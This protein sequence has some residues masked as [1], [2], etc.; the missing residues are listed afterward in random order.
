MSCQNFEAIIIGMARAQ[1]LEASARREALAHIAQCA[2]CADKL[3]EQQALTAAVRVTARNLAVEGASAGV[4]HALRA[5][6]RAQPA[7][8]AASAPSV[9]PAQR[10]QLAR[11]MVFAAAAILLV[12]FFAGLIWQRLQTDQKTALATTPPSPAPTVSANPDSL[13][14]HFPTLGLPVSERKQQVA[15]KPR[16]MRPARRSSQTSEEDM[17][18]GFIALAEAG[19]LAPLESGQVL[20]VELSVSTLISMGLPIQA[21]DVSKPVLADLLLG[22]DGLARAIR[23]VKPGV[24]AD[25]DAPQTATNR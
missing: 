19:E 7:F 9:A 6:F 21:A 17:T 16:Q 1:L 20:R 18:A 24:A 4:E 25:V 5:A 23:F 3:A 14:K 22:Q 10:W 15:S 11:R 13:P 2:T 12:V 8:N